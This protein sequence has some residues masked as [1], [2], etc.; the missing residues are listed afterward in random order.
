M[1]IPHFSGGSDSKESVC[2]AG[3]PGSIPESGRSPDREGDGY[4]LQ[5]TYLGNPMA[6]GA[7]RATVHGI[8]KSWAQLKQMSS[9]SYQAEFC[10]FS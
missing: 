5:Y 4:P 6:R 9:L 3:D 10:F 8:T 1:L 2:N 7:W